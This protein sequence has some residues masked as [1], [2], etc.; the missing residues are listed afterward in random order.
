MPLV[1]GHRS[2][3][4]LGANT[5]RPYLD[6]DRAMLSAT[7]EFLKT[8]MRVRLEAGKGQGVKLKVTVE[9]E[10]VGHKFPTGS[11]HAADV[12]CQVTVTDARGRVVFDDGTYTFGA[13]A[14]DQDGT[15]LHRGDLWNMAGQLNGLSVFPGTYNF[16]NFEFKPEP[17]SVY[18][19]TAV[20][21]L[22]YRKYNQAF[23]SFVLTKRPPP[24]GAG[25]TGPWTPAAQLPVTA[26]ARAATT[27]EER[28]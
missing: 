8:G 1:D 24:D 22:R 23:T 18:P 5:A 20:A 10:T 13:R 3:L 15:W 11:V 26:L 25:Y 9:N 7:Q 19:L 4:F 17:G 16:R 21:E 27:I 6:G 2:H 12:W 28:R 14:V